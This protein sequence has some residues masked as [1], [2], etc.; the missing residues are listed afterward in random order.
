MD[1][2]GVWGPWSKTWSF[3]ARGPAHPLDVA[4]DYDEATGAAVLRWKANPAGCSPVK[5]RVYGSDEKGFTVS[6][7]R[8]Q[9]TVGVTKKEMAEWDPWFPANFIAETTARELEVLG[10]GVD[11][12]TAN[13]TYYRVVAVDENGK[14]SGP[15]DYATAPRPVIYSQPVLTASV[16]AEY[17][18]P[19]RATRSLGDLTSRMRENKQVKGYFDIEKLKFALRRGPPWLTID[20]TTGVLSGVPDAPGKVEV[21]VVATIEREVR[22]LDE[23][24]LAWGNEKVLSTATERVGSARQRFVIEVQPGRIA[25][26]PEG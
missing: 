9:S 10:C 26:A 13:K 24:V 11:L 19:L 20:E 21:T 23:K 6:D 22:T 12:P 18:Y 1:A 17:C 7:Q 3:I 8:Y 5:Y 14:R 15:S 2:K 16:A 25:T 4:V